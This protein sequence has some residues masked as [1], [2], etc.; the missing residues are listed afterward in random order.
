MDE[1]EDDRTLNCALRERAYVFWDA[2]RVRQPAIAACL[3]QARDI[4]REEADRLY[5][6]K[7]SF[8]PSVQERLDAIS[9]YHDDRRNLM[10]QIQ[11]PCFYDDKKDPED[12]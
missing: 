11:G 1:I 3:Q 9:I 5:N 8:G 7:A 12:D 10:K 4:P 2:E 6:D